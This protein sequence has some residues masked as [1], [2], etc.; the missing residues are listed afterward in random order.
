MSRISR[1]SIVSKASLLPLLAAAIWLMFH[2]AWVS[3][4]AYITF[5]SVENFL[6]GYGP[7][8]NV[9]ERVQTFTHPLWFF[10]QA[11]INAI[12]QRIGALNPWAQVYFV[13]VYLCIALS[14]GAILI[15]ALGLARS[16][17]G[18]W[19]C[20]AV[21][22][23][24][25]AFIDYTTSGLENALSYFL[26]AAFLYVLF[27]R[28]EMR[29]WRF[30]GLALIAGL[31]TLNRMDTLLLFI[32]AL[33]YAFRQ[34]HAPKKAAF[35]LGLGF[36]PF[37]IWEL[38]S[39]F[40]YGFPFPN[41]AYAKLNTGISKLDLIQQGLNYYRSSILLDPI[42][43]VV[44]SG[45]LVWFLW[46]GSPQHRM[47]VLGVLA[48]LAYILYIGGDFMGARFFAVPLLSCAA[49]LSTIE[50]K[51][52]L[53]YAGILLVVILV[54]LLNPL[55]PLRSQRGY[56]PVDSQQLIDED[57]V[58]DER[59]Y[60]YHDL[61]LLSTSREKAF[62]G[63][64]HAGRKWIFDPEKRKV[65]LVGPLGV[66]GYQAGPD[67]HMIDKNGLADP[68]MVR[69][70]L[71]DPR[72]WRI[73]H[74]KHI[75]P[76]GYLNTLATGKNKILDPNLARYYDILAFVTRGPLWDARRLIEIIKLNTGAYDALLEVY[77]K[78]WEIQ[79]RPIDQY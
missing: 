12:T 68:L 19:L 4:D 17:K 24:S 58:A 44:L 25:K 21:L 64:V 73:G 7:V 76:E 41:T 9:G 77:I 70:P 69:L 22:M 38:F 59:L 3:D 36:L 35:L 75:I 10:I 46:K 8:Y 72:H 6:A 31:A 53:A 11:G 55:T 1:L 27:L 67:I 49:L 29:L 71:I 5:R 16:P 74:F 30:F 48:Y 61:G 79:G 33:I 52:H 54:G 26:L 40:Y 57:G 65:V 14:S 37:F 18:A 66:R 60:Y 20:L 28:G 63:S 50:Y 2:T 34:S 39:L 56:D 23:L 15:L 78:N 42:I 32:P 13:S 45:S 43:L 47:V 62:P 51:S